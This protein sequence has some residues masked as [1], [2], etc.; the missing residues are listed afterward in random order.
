MSRLSSI[1]AGLF[2]LFCY[3]GVAL[4]LD[5]APDKFEEKLK[6]YDPA[7]VAAAREYMTTLGMK[8]QLEKG[9]AQMRV[10]LTAQL[11][12]KNPEIDDQQ[13][14]TFFKA[15]FKSAFVDDA[16]I[17]ERASLLVILDIF[18]KDELTAITQ[19]YS[20]PM[21]QRVLAKMPTV[22]GRLPELVDAVEKYVLPKAL[23]RALAE[24][25]KSGVQM[26]L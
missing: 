6:T 26:K 15:F 23:A 8:Q 18:T 24:V 2:A 9:A 19:F 3:C 7:T 20:S 10:A 21:G 17:I 22:M 5:I 16:P 1:A 14:D 13:L 4:A 12:A 11:K 25:E